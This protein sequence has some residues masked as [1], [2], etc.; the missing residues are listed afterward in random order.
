MHQAEAPPPIHV[1]KEHCEKLHTRFADRYQN[2]CEIVVILR[3]IQ[4]I[5]VT[6]ILSCTPGHQRKRERRHGLFQVS[7]L[8]IP[9]SC[10]HIFCDLANQIDQIQNQR[11][12]ARIVASKIAGSYDEQLTQQLE[13]ASVLAPAH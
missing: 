9:S 7:S 6:F 4:R 5:S 13:L 10:G 3:R 2:N 1:V 11:I 12:I 8:W